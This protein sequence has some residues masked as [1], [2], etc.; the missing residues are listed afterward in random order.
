MRI[1]HSNGIKELHPVPTSEV[2]DMFDRVGCQDLN[3]LGRET[4][5]RAR[6]CARC[7]R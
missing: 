2:D 3:I 5:N 6:S 4:P 7:K 1:I